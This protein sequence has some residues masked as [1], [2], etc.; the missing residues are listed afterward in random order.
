MTVPQ[1][2]PV[3]G[4]VVALPLRSEGESGNFKC[5]YADL[6][7]IGERRIVRTKSAAKLLDGCSG[8]KTSLFS[9]HLIELMVLNFCHPSIQ[10]SML[11]V[12]L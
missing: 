9:C 12:V 6:I 1:R 8:C 11:G 4:K 10:C 3:S 2:V 5:D 7:F